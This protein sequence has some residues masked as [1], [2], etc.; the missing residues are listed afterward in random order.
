MSDS[1]N[2]LKKDAKLVKRL[3]VTVSVYLALCA[4]VLIQMQKCGLKN[5]VFYASMAILS[6][7][8]LMLVFV[9][10]R[11]YN[12]EREEAFR[13]SNAEQKPIQCQIIMQGKP[14]TTGQVST[15]GQN[16]E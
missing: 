11:L 13:H 9:F 16:P 14:T 7:L 3:A 5:E 4:A 1:N 2:M 6:I 15:S 10:V 8:C 12:D